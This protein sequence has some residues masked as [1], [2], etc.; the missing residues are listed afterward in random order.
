MI[1]RQRSRRQANTFIQDSLPS[2][3]DE[4]GENEIR[5]V[6]EVHG[7][8]ASKRRRIGSEVRVDG[9]ATGL[10]DCNNTGIKNS[11]PGRVVIT[12][13]GRTKS[14]TNARGPAGDARSSSP[15]VQSRR[16]GNRPAA[17]R[18]VGRNDLRDGSLP[19]DAEE[20]MMVRSGCEASG[21]EPNNNDELLLADGRTANS[22][23]RRTKGTTASQVQASGDGVEL[24]RIEGPEEIIQ[25]TPS[26][27]RRTE[28]P[29]DQY[30]VIGRLTELVGQLIEEKTPTS[31][32]QTMKV[33]SVP[34]F[35]PSARKFTTKQWLQ[36]IEQFQ[37]MFGWTEATTIYHMQ[38]RLKGVARDWYDSLE[39]Y[40][41]S[42]EEWKN[43]LQTTFPEPRDHA[44]MMDKMK[45]RI[46]LPNETYEAYYFA[47]LTLLRPCHLSPLQQVDHIIDGITDR[48]V[49]CTAKAGCYSSP[50]E[51]YSN[52]MLPFSQEDSRWNDRSENKCG[53]C[54]KP[55]HWS[56][57]CTQRPKGKDHSRQGSTSDR[58][59]PSDRFNSDHW[60]SSDRVKGENRE[61]SS[62]RSSDEDEKQQKCNRCGARGHAAENCRTKRTNFKCFN[63]GDTGHSARACPKEK[64][65]CTK[66]NK[67][68][69]LA[70]KCLTVKAVRVSDSN[71]D[72][73]NTVPERT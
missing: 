24:E 63:C 15:V 44:I 27:Q 43:T 19:L 59:K 71:I 10:N 72:P 49:R 55:G 31:S 52:G 3:E 69:H 20:T 1:T 5:V 26:Q 29:T 37:N 36:S 61:S 35:D 58:S 2:S 66:C 4:L 56:R 12:R 22:R 64:K 21:L 8:A 46:K 48:V 51:L 70:E 68:G 32:H 16:T 9:L 18:S 6:A 40:G 13:S 50:E 23:A 53:R 7:P 28:E 34:E 25:P 17:F 41:L 60:R 47:K 62:D 11:V 30:S 42:W 45:D 73:E 33:E 38:A 54:G 57:E 14:G 67:F 65:Q 39:Y